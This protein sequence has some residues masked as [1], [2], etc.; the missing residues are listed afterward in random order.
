M[1]KPT[2]LSLLALAAV[3]AGPLRAGAPS[4]AAVAPLPDAS[5]SILRTFDEIERGPGNR[6]IKPI[7]SAP[8][9]IAGS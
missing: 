7:V 8:G 6:P 9:P 4:D 3:L 2:L 1:V 5:S